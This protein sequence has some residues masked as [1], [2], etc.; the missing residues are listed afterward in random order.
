MREDVALSEAPPNM[1]SIEVT[2][3][4]S[5]ADHCDGGILK[6]T[7]DEGDPS[8]MVLA[9]GMSGPQCREVARQLLIIADAA[10]GGA[11]VTMMCVTHS[12]MWKMP[13]QALIARRT[14][15][16]HFEFAVKPVGPFSGPPV[17]N[18][19]RV[20]TPNRRLIVP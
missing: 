14:P 3:I 11:E 7:K 4:G 5:A 8:E 13:G 6:L 17:N 16:P 12:S 1:V 2:P 9:A 10:S 19:R 15:D 18:G 20:V